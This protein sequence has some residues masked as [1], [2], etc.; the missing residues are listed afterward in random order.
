MI[1]TYAWRQTRCMRNIYYKYKHVLSTNNT[2]R[3]SRTQGKIMTKAAIKTTL[4][5]LV[6]ASAVISSNSMANGD[7]YGA[8][9]MAVGGGE[10]AHGIIVL[11][12]VGLAVVTSRFTKK[13]H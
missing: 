9:E 13:G 8:R 1:N 3:I 5:S 4:T 6:A 7:S 10:L 11:V 12:L 2:F